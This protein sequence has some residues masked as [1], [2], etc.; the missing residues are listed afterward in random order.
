MVEAFNLKAAL[1]YGL[2]NWKNAREALQ[3]LPPRKEEELDPVTLMNH[4]LI[5]FDQDPAG[6]FRKLAFLLAHPP[7]PRETLANLLLLYAKHEY[8]ELAADLLAE[9]SDTAPN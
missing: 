3:D 8:F 1:E 6:G 2:K 9:N 5:F 7:S 4:A